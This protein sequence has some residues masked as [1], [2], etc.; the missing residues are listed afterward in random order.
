MNAKNAKN[1][2]VSFVNMRMWTNLFFSKV[3][4]TD[5]FLG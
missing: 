2:M 3:A 4:A 1:L 5:K